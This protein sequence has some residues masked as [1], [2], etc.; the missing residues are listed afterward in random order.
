MDR[1][2]KLFD[3]VQQLVIFQ[4]GLDKKRFKIVDRG[5]EGKRFFLVLERRWP[6][7]WF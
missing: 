4:R 5:Q 7:I 6:M 3:N 1:E 2:R